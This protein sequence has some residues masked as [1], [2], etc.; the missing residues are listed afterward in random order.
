[1]N[2]D[3]AWGMVQVSALYRFTQWL[4]LKPL[5]VNNE[6]YNSMWQYFKDLATAIN[7]VAVIPAWKN[8]TKIDDRLC[9]HATW[10]VIDHIDVLDTGESNEPA[11]P[12]LR[13]HSKVVQSLCYV[14]TTEAALTEQHIVSVELR[15]PASR[16]IGLHSARL[17]SSTTAKNALIS[18]RSARES[19]RK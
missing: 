18:R 3:S 12:L 4:E 13:L 2:L 5:F 17:R 10:R 11:H 19:T 9:N 15:R 7:P 14:P 1:M 16:L 8:T 6:L